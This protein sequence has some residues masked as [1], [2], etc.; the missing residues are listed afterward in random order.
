MST[1]EKSKTPKKSKD[2]AVQERIKELSEKP[3]VELTLSD[4]V[5]GTVRDALEL[6]AQVIELAA[7]VLSV[8][9]SGHNRTAAKRTVERISRIN[10]EYSDR[11]KEANKKIVAKFIGESENEKPD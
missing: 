8:D 1:L 10:K 4:I 3:V 6:N 9:P 5:I 11:L 7:E 2:T